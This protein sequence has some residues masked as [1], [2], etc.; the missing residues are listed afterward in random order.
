[1]SDPLRD[2]TSLD[3]VY[4]PQDVALPKA[5]IVTHEHRCPDG[6]VVTVR[7]QWI[8]TT[9]VTLDRWVVGGRVVARSARQEHN[10]LPPDFTWADTPAAAVA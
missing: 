3:G 10:S 8:A 5:D 6:I 1:M 2:P 4:W 9:G 7:S